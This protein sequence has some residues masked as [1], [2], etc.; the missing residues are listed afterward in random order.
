MGVTE[1]FPDGRLSLNKFILFSACL[2]SGSYF[3]LE[4]SNSATSQDVTYF[5]MLHLQKEHKLKHR[6]VQVLVGT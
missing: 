6:V 3:L 1:T 4:L 2:S 5:S